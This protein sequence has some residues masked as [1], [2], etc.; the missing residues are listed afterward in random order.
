MQRSWKASEKRLD[1]PK[2]FDLFKFPFTL[3]K[4]L[5]NSHKWFPFRFQQRILTLYLVLR[6]IQNVSKL[7]ITKFVLFQ[8]VKHS[9]GFETKRPPIHG[10]I[11]NFV[12]GVFIFFS[13]V[14]LLS[15]LFGFSRDANCSLPS[16][17]F[18][19]QRSF[20]EDKRTSLRS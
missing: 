7:K 15:F 5:L 9:F 6:R 2:V 8:V 17:S 10:Q 18:G 3:S 16:S 20:E 12:I 11:T 14:C 4:S 19:F 13:R 1:S